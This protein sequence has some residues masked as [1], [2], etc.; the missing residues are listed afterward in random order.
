MSLN[1]LSGLNFGLLSIL[2]AHTMQKVENLPH[3]FRFYGSDISIGG[4]LACYKVDIKDTFQPNRWLKRIRVMDLLDELKKLITKLN[5]EKIEYA[6]C[7]GLAMA[8]YALPRATLDIDILIEASSL[9]T[10]RRAVYDLGFTLKAA[11]MEFHG[12]KVHIHRVSK[13]EPGYRR[14]PYVG[15]AD[16]H[17]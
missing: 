1:P 11:P 3:L 17:T 14:D 9:E 12:G 7:G 10:T 2:S 5:E 13:I 4:A 8:I 16:R 15:F 6:L